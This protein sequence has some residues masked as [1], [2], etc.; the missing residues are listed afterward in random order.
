MKVKFYD[1]RAKKP[2]MIDMKDIKEE[3]SKNGRKMMVAMH[4]GHKLYKFTK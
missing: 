2:V 1:I 3:M 4:N